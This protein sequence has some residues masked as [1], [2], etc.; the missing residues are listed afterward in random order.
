MVVAP[1][2]PARRRQRQ[3][4]LSEFE[5]S[6]VHRVISRT[7]GNVSQR[8]PAL[9]NKN[10]QTNK[11]KKIRREKENMGHISIFSTAIEV[12]RQKDCWRL[13]PTYIYIKCHARKN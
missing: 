12:L 5:T 6:L 10:K 1:L 3:V 2:I 8:N 7:A 4:E 11:R 9:K 13:R